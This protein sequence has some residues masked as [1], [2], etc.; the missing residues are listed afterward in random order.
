M[1]NRRTYFTRK[2][3]RSAK[4]E[5]TLNP[6]RSKKIRMLVKVVF[7]VSF[8]GDSVLFDR[9]Y[10][11]VCYNISYIAEEWLGFLEHW[12]WVK[13]AFPN[14]LIYYCVQGV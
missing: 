4:R 1:K 14:A 13:G 3:R 5:E 7:M 12:Y 11:H 9:P 10:R 8:L 2:P 6:L